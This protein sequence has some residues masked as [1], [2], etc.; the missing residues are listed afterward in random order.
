[1]SIAEQITRIKTN[2]SNAYDKCEA[3]GA[4]IPTDKNSDNLATT[5]DSITGGGA[6]KYGITFD[7]IIG[8]T[9]EN[10][11]LL[12]PKTYPNYTEIV[13][14][15]VKDLV[16]N[17]LPYRFYYCQ[18]I[19]SVSFPDLEKISGSTSCQ[20]TFS[21]V[22]TGL[23]SISFPKLETISGNNACSSMFQSCN[24]ITSASFPNLVSITGIGSC[25]NMFYGCSGALTLISFPK[26]KTISGSSGCSSM[27][28]GCRSL[29]S[30]IYFPDLETI[31]GNDVC[32]SMFQS[33]TNLTSISFPKLKTIS[34]GCGSMFMGCTG[35][36]S[37]SFPALTSIGNTAS[38]CQ[39]MFASCSSIQNVSFPELVSINAVNACANMFQGCNTLTSVSFPKLSLI[40][41]SLSC[42]NMFLGCTNL[43]DIYFNSLNTSS[44]S[45][46]KNQFNNMLGNTGTT[47]THT[48]HFPS[49]MQ[50]TISTLSAYPLFGGTSGYVV[51]SFDLP[52]TE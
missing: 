18:T 12:R 20:A 1:M 23:T 48:I 29:S 51:L 5:I 30:P 44:F 32:S 13:F 10:G 8:N 43:T 17:C 28:N 52:A 24:G 40:N 33:C 11:T 50:P 15:G 35:I 26:L 31:S 7:T 9:D 25:Q 27:F 6:T 21:S 45:S 2:I 38:S 39:S 36:T 37:I 16:D 42:A 41:G 22:G 49:N 46:L 19:K 34:A 47:T 14:D 3:K 4:T